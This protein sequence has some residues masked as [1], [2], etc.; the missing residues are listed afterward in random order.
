MTVRLICR[1]CPL[2]SHEN[3]ECWGVETRGDVPVIAL[4]FSDSDK[5]VYYMLR[6]VIRFEVEK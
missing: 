2:L 6:N 4:R 1:G 3:V 5:I